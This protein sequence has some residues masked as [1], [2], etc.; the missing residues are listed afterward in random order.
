MA[1][2]YIVLGLERSQEQEEGCDQVAHKHWY[3]RIVGHYRAAE[4][5]LTDLE[6][7]H[8]ILLSSSPSRS[9][10]SFPARRFS[11]SLALGTQC[12]P[13][14]LPIAQLLFHLAMRV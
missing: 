7:T 14:R 8:L 3:I 4:Q 1:E 10:V 2:F 13:Y 11:A 6:P 5:R 12:L 9:I